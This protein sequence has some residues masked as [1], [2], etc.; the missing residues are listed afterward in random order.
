MTG[1]RFAAPLRLLAAIAALALVA[2]GSDDDTGTNTNDDSSTSSGVKAAQ[3]AIKPY[4]DTPS[5]FPVTEPLREVPTGARIAFVDCG[6]PTCALLWTLVQAA[7]KTMGVD[8][9]RVKAGQSADTV[10]SAFDTVVSQQPDGVIVTSIDPRLWQAQ[11]EELQDA[12]IPIVT[13]GIVDAADYGI[14]SPQ[15]ARPESKRDGALLADYVAANFGSDANVALYKV[16]EL[17]FTRVVAEAFTTELE[18]VCPDCSVRTVDIPAATLG[19]TAPSRIV[20]DLQ[21]N[22]DTS[23]AAFTVDEIQTGLPAAMN[24]AGI[25][26]ETIGNGPGPTNLQYIKDGQEKAGLGVDIP[27]LAW[28]AV[29]QVAREITGQKLTGD[30][31]KGLTAIQFL[32]RKDI[33]FDPSNG[34][35]G[36]PD[37]AKRFAKLWGVAD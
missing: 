17:S 11:L 25:E 35:S 15:Y 31:A 24:A 14:E 12:D 4:L 5:P 22:S 23:V 32:T 36:Y 26:V 19:N 1:N 7:G 34:W 29:D 20:S 2:C 27:V 6:T 10:R 8:L 30:Q 13:T 37:F 28:T 18:R 3:A 21:A 33:V 9:T 16:P